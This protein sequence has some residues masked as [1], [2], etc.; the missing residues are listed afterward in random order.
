LNLSFPLV[1]SERIAAHTDSKGH[2]YY[3][4][5]VHNDTIAFLFCLA[6]TVNTA[7]GAVSHI[8]TS[9]SSSL[10]HHFLFFCR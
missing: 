9:I 8:P 3:D 4:E 10:F 7:I 5:K 2:K 1:L 6:L